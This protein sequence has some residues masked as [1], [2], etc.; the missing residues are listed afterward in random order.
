VRRVPPRRQRAALEALLSTLD[1]RALALPEDVLETLPPR[2][3]GMPEGETLDRRTAPTFDY[4]EAASA[5]ARYTLRYLLQ[6]QRMAR[7]VDQAARHGGD[8][9][10]P[11]LREVARRLL[12]ATWHA[13]APA[14]ARLAAVHRVVERAVLDRLLEEAAR[15]ANPARVRGV[16][17][18]S[19]QGLARRLEARDELSPHRRDAL[20][21]IRRFQR[22]EQAPAE[23]SREPELPPGSPIGGGR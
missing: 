2:A 17:E 18:A 21:T 7:L 23:P 6:P 9:G 20:E 13:D 10:T 16:L 4:L 8:E 19:L 14:A 12:E 11:G 5:A 3:F 22:R 1:A 15:P